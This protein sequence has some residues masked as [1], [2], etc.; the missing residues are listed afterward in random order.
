MDNEQFKE[1][2]AFAVGIT[3]KSGA[4]LL[5]YFQRPMN[6]EYKSEDQT[7]PVTDADKHSE[8]YLKEAILK[9]YPD[10]AI[11]AEEGSQ[12]ESQTSDFTWVLD[13]LDGTVNFVNGLPIFG[14]SVG[15]LHKGH[16]VVGC[17][18]VPSPR[19][20]TGN[21]F[22][23][24]Q[25]GG[26]FRDDE[27]IQ[28]S[29][30]PKPKRSR[31]SIFPGYY[32]RAFSLKKGLRGQVGELRSPGSVAYEL[33][34]TASGVIQFSIFNR[35]WVWDVAAGVVLVSESKGVALVR[36]PKQRHWEPFRAFATQ[37]GA[38]LALKELK[39]WRTPWL[40]GNPEMT[41]FVA[42]HMSP[43]TRLGLMVTRL[44]RRWLY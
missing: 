28:V 35:P 32:V 8:E 13:P 33:A 17:I 23:A 24:R 41:R 15:V 12:V 29:Q 3:R 42:S 31:I 9:E 26:A 20:P 30:D 18:F 19:S 5:D 39:D 25:D 40:F 38:G 1:I 16:P 7:N 37:Q 27:P 36:Q 4:I 2:E 22:H 21:I 43:R 6:V 11:L 14:V 34:L 10:H 44:L